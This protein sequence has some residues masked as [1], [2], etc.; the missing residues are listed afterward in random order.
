M[1]KKV[2]DGKILMVFAEDKFVDGKCVF[3]V[4]SG[5]PM[6]VP[7]ESVDRWLKR[8]GQIVG[9]DYKKEFEVDQKA[10][11][12][13]T[14]APLAHEMKNDGKVPHSEV[15]DADKKAD[16]LKEKAEEIHEANAEEAASV[17]EELQAEQEEKSVEA[18]E[19]HEDEGEE[20][21]EEESE[22][23]STK[24]RSAKKKK[25]KKKKH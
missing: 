9:S 13:E 12:A 21:E 18:E 16:A 15:V 2:E 6:E 19:G 17:E 4:Q 1:K 5:E 23:D 20:H 8:G 24:P 25:T 7:K 3:A 10:I 11:E 14:D 22:Q